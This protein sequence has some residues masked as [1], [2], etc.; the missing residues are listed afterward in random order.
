MRHTPWP[1][2]ASVLLTAC[3]QPTPE[4]QIVNDAAEALG[5]RD[6]ILA[7]RTLVLEGEGINGNLGQDMTPDATGQTFTVSAY[8]RAVDVAGGRVR[9]EQTRRPNSVFFQGRPPQN[10]V[11]GLDGEV[12][13]N[14]AADGTATR[15]SD[16]VARDRRAEFYHHPLTILRA[17]LDP[18]TT[19]GNPRTL[20]S[21][22]VVEVKTSGGA[23][24]TLATDSTTN[25]P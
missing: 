17:A 15:A 21:Q 18:T 13:Y 14:V 2:L 10:Q 19:L 8:R 16:A 3:A 22:R 20:E 11:Q 1:V 9:V 5:G 25:L 24:F 7:A 23:T 12:A 4:Q 6:R